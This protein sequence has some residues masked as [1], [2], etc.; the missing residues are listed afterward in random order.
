MADIRP[1]RAFRPRPELAGRVASPP[2]DVL[3]S[4]EARTMAADEPLSFLHVVKAEIDLPP[5]QKD[6]HETVYAKSAENLKALMDD[7]ALVRD[8]KPA[9]Y[10]YRLTM[11]DHQQYGLAAG[12]AVQ[13]YVDGTIKKHEFTRRDKE[14]DRARHME[15]LGVNAG[16]VLFTYRPVPALRE[17]IARL[18]AGK[19]DTD[20]VADDGIGHTVW[21]VDGEDDIRAIQEI[22][23]GID[24]IYVAD[25]HH[26]TASAHRVRDIYRDR[27][28]N[29]TGDEAYNH[30]LAVMFSEDELQLMG[31]H[32]VLKDLNGLSAEEFLGKVKDIFD[33]TETD[34]PAPAGH[35]EW[36]MFLG[37]RWYNIKARPGTFPA[38]DP[39][40]GL[41]AAIL[42]DLLLEPVL[43]IGDPRKDPRIDFVGG[44]R[45]F[46]E[47]ERRCGVDCQVAFA[48][49]PASVSQI[50][51]VAD[52]DAV[53]PPKS[54]WFEPKLR[55]GLLV[56]SLTD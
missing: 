24:A 12:C 10:I 56:R 23:Q 17:I 39:V 42:Q 32:R 25:G 30:F 8:D 52:A 9:F 26:R 49:A 35:T 38:D 53:M 28:A 37:G 50:M 31:Y 34:D 20:F 13:E 40:K 19:P 51:A 1:F 54:T 4:E 36:G 55:S 15:I 16:P 14:D 44:S 5:E 47:L 6:D 22:F 11:G 21:V 43:G 33:V 18:S 27:N 2:Y 7:Q 45:G 46:G 48:F 41:D 29:H 3:D